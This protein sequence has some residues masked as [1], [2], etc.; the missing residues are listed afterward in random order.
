MR[1][2]SEIPYMYSRVNIDVK[3]KPNESDVGD[4]T[5]DYLKFVLLGDLK[6]LETNQ[7]V[8]AQDSI[9]EESDIDDNISLD[10]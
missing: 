9:L 4:K 6:K 2:R 1:P 8:E 10:D 5:F 3:Q 7:N